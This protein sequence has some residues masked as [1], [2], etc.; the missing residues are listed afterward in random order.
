[1]VSDERGGGTLADTR[2]YIG[3]YQDTTGLSYLNARYYDPQRGQFLSEDSQFWSLDRNWLADPQNQNSYSYGRNNPV[4]HKDPSGKCFEDLCIGEAILA[5]SLLAQ[6]SPQLL[7]FVQSLT[8]PVG[9]IGISQALDD[10]KS[11]RY[12]WAVFGALTSGELPEGRY[13]PVFDGLWS[14][15][16]K[17][18]RA[19]NAIHHALEAGRQEVGH[20]AEFGITNTKDYI[21]ATREF[22]A[23]AINKNLPTKLESHKTFDI[24]RT[25]DSESNTFSVF[26]VNKSTNAITPRTMFKPTDGG[27][28]FKSEVKGVIKNIHNYFKK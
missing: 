17:A 5:T 26:E 18:D 13:A 28:Y 6:Y 12:G 9:Q 7:S 27:N 23:E 20:A 15:G 19:A 8:T 25:Y 4:I 1:M 2:G 22:I 11:N 10:A 16:S 3:E 21:K 24:L 14:V